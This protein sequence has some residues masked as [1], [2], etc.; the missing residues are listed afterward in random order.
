MACHSLHCRGEHAVH[1]A[2][3]PSEN[4]LVSSLLENN[5]VTVMV[6]AVS[7]TTSAA[8]AHSC[9]RAH[10]GN[11]PW[12]AYPP[13]RITSAPPLSLSF[14][15]AVLRWGRRR[16]WITL[17][18]QI[19]GFIIWKLHKIQFIPRPVT[20]FHDFRQPTEL[21]KKT[22]AISIAGWYCYVVCS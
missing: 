6:V 16:T 10:S 2:A 12:S 4:L 9:L 19:V 13:V 8:E 1:P 18:A 21:Q 11:R 15:G 5:L 14:A 17:S 7:W 3:L 20:I 22:S